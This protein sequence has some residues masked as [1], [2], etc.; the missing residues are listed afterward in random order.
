MTRQFHINLNR[1]EGYLQREARRARLRTQ[2]TNVIASVLLLIMTYLTFDNDKEIRGIVEG[3][4][5]QLRRIIAQIDSLQKVG[6]NVSKDDVLALARLDRDRVL[7]TK[8]FFAMAERLPKKVVVTGLK[9]Q[10]GKLLINS[11][12]EVIS[13]ERDFDNVKLFMDRL[14][15]TPLFFEDISAMKFKESTRFVKHEQELLDFS[16]VCDIRASET[17][18]SRRSGTRRT[19]PSTG[20]R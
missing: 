1:E 2:I 13:D 7:W 3:K 17:T 16:V 6:Q 20:S 9:L 15:A 14:R 8:K 12:T 19:A 4:E 11:M 5:L 18:R 10:R